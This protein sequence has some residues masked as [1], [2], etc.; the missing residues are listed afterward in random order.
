MIFDDL[1]KLVTVH[2]VDR[3]LFGDVKLPDSVEGDIVQVKPI[4]LDDDFIP[5][6]RI[7]TDAKHQKVTTCNQVLRTYHHQTTISQLS[8][9]CSSD[10]HFLALQLSV[11]IDC[12]LAICLCEFEPTVNSGPL[13]H[14]SFLNCD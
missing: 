8:R 12:P 11:V 1:M 7:A 3:F 5:T 4:Q 6:L 13:T 10:V 14:D 9:N 2:I